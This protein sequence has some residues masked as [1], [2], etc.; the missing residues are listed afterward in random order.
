MHRPDLPQRALDVVGWILLGSGL[1]HVV[2]WV[3]QGGEWE[4]PLS[5]RKPILFGISTGLTALSLAWLWSWTPPRSRA[6]TVAAT[7]TALA[8]LVEVA[9]VDVQCWRGRASHFNHD[10]PLDGAVAD[11]MNLL[12]AGVT[13]FLAW[14]AARFLRGTPRRDGIAMDD[15]TLLAARAG[16]VLLVWSCALGFWAT[17]HGERQ[18]AAGRPP[19]L[20]GAA[21]VTKFAHGAAIH[22]IQWL[23]AIAWLAAR[24]GLSGAV[25]LRLVRLGVAA[26]S[27]V[28]VASLISVLQ[29]RARS[30][31]APLSAALFLAAAGCGIAVC[32]G[33]RRRPSAT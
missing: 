8:L 31:P 13:L 33:L 9:L 26:S 23:P 30:D 28:A 16:L 4:G 19:E 32:I 14:L 6:A 11:V 5:W 21:G 7:A 29:G 2:V 15:A 1:L 12:I 25:R 3:V 22:A 17:W 27:L 18:I 24:R 20:H 10:T